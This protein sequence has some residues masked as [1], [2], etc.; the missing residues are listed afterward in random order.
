MFAKNETT[1]GGRRRPIYD[2]VH[3]RTVTKKGSTHALSTPAR[4]VEYRAESG[5]LNHSQLSFLFLQPVRSGRPQ[6]YHTCTRP[7]LPRGVRP[8]P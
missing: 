2:V 8:G 6:Y 1:L 5:E 4:K 3:D 7:D